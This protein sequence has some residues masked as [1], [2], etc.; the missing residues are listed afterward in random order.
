MMWFGMTWVGIVALG[1]VKDS[2]LKPG[3]PYRLTHATDYLGNICGYDDVVKS[4]PNSYYLPDG[5]GK[6]LA[7]H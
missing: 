4:K 2:R 1:G 6:L 7:S 5:S 3:N